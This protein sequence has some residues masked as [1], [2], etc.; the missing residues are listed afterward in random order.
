MFKNK[1]KW[2][3]SLTRRRNWNWRWDNI[4]MIQIS[5]KNSKEEIE[6]L[7][8]DRLKTL[9]WDQTMSIKSPIQQAQNWRRVI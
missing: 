9:K 6:S 3:P 5:S 4:W 2:R 1:I 8:F 7:D